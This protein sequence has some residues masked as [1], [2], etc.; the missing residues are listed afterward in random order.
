[1]KNPQHVRIVIVG[2]YGFDNLGDD[3]ILRAALKAIRE[4]VP[5]AEVA[6]LSNNPFETAKRHRGET[7]TYSPEALVRQIISRTM[8]RI[9]GTYK[10]Y[11]LP[12]PSDAFRQAWVLIR[13][14][15]LVLSLG[16]GYL[17]DNSRPPY[18]H[19]RLGELAFS[20]LCGKKVIMCAHELGPFHRT[21]SILIARLAVKS[22]VYATV[23]DRRSQEVLSNFGFPRERIL[24]TA[25][26]SW[27]YDPVRSLRLNVERRR[28][29][30]G[31]TM[32]VNLMPLQIVSKANLSR[33]DNESRA[34]EM[35]TRILGSVASCCETTELIQKHLYFLSMSSKDNE[36]AVQLRS[37]LGNRLQVDEVSDLDSQYR[38]LACS[39]VMIGMRMHSIIMA[40]QLEVPPIAI[41]AL[42]KVR[43]TMND[44]GL[45][46]YTVDIDGFAPR[47][48]QRLF[49]QALTNSQRIR[50]VMVKRV[51][52]LKEKATQNMRPVQLSM[53]LAN[54]QTR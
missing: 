21:S 52:V 44:L 13:K 38:A 9:S 43:D 30:K 48:L 35:N 11:V 40:A 3:L 28:R 31:I 36:M 17:N 37:I 2:G 49:S 42:P 6:V 4:A 51:R 50:K 39:N 20:G 32:A 10:N 45:S 18:P 1:L 47:R 27:A 5:D 53:Q 33:E 34:T 16:G 24:R 7:V 23:R 22:L 19:L 41:A 26:E 14:A 29:R 8:S 12:I 46:M 25:D 15:N 54:A